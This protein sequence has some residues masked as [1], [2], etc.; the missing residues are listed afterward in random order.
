MAEIKVLKGERTT[1]GP[2]GI[3]QMGTGGIRAARQMQES[4]KRIFEESFKFLVA[5]ETKEGKR[6]AAN[7]AM[8]ARDKDGNWVVPEI[9]QS[10]S[11]VAKEAYEPI[12]NKRYI[13][14][15]G[16]EIDKVANETASKHKRDPEG[17]NVE[18]GSFL[19]GLRDKLKD[20]QFVGAVGSIGLTN[21]A[22]YQKALFNDRVAFEDNIAAANAVQI[23]DKKAADI[24]AVAAKGL[25]MAG[26][27]MANA[28]EQA[29][30]DSVQFTRQLGKT[31]L[32]TIDKKL[33]LSFTSGNLTSIANKLA[34]S[35]EVINPDAKQPMLAADLSYMAIALG[36]RSLQNIPAS[37]RK[38]LEKAGFTEKYITDPL[39]NGLHD[40]LARDI[41]TKKN[42]V[43]EQYNAQKDLTLVQAAITNFGN[44]GIASQSDADLIMKY[45]PVTSPETFVSNLS[46][47]MIPPQS[48][49]ARNEWDRQ[50]GAVHDLLFE[51]RG[52]LPTVAKDFL[53]NIDAMQPEQIPVAIAM[54]QQATQFNQGS[55]M[56]RKVS[57]GLE[58]KT[59][60]MYETLGAV[61]DTLGPASVGEFLQLYRDAINMT[62]EN[63]KATLLSRTGERKGTADSVVRKFV[64]DSVDGD[65]SDDE[66]NFYTQYADELLLT[67]GEKTTRNILKQA[68]EKI[69][70]ESEFLH[71]TIGRSRFTP[72]RAYPSNLE[73][74]DFK[75]AASMRLSLVNSSLKLGETAFLVPDTREGTALPV[76]NLVDVNKNPIIYN[77]K[78]LQVGNQLV[79]KRMAKR[80]K[81]TIDAL[82]QEA[83]LAEDQYVKLRQDINATGI[84][85]SS[86]FIK[87]R[88]S[89][90]KQRPEVIKIDD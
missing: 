59:V 51:N 19:D 47:I 74:F 40:Q 7:A 37:A 30:G 16:I 43:Q 35:A 18:F 41:T 10:L 31:W 65:A 89:F 87:A 85:N 50:F 63:R 29:Q 48:K 67:V 49:A 45:S 90:A 75:E 83:Q 2:V 33:R 68:S 22:Q 38:R 57:R 24:E 52:K 73:M 76:Y 72:E 86:F 17:F 12:A 69:F 84:S 42:R 20:T 58:K 71:P 36:D 53:E 56:E 62:P 26:P 6:E 39:F 88:E 55:F 14:S 64:I 32:P 11:Y 61:M 81:I 79:L 5:E 28:I 21:S 44:N 9:P 78:M 82:R 77:G 13:D 66:I 15:L 46:T 60:V 27:M 8:G 34:D 25:S 4:G 54:Y 1:V 80:R 23:L 70:K 3:V